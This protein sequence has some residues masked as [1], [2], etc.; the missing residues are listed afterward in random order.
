[1]VTRAPRWIILAALALVA[2]NLRSVLTSLPPLVTEIQADTGWSDVTIGLLTT[3]PVLLMGATAL[4]VPR[5]AEHVGRIQTVWL[6]LALLTIAVLARLA[7]AVPGVLHASVI[8]AGI[9]IA[10]AA[11][12]VPG[13]V[14][15]QVPRAIGPATGIWT[16]AMFTGATL[17]A[18]LAVPFAVAAGSWQV[19]LAVWAI[20]AAVAFVMWAIVETPYRRHVREGIASVRISALPWHS[21][22]AW[23]LTAYLALNSLVFYSAV[24][25]LAPSLDERGWSAAESGWLFAL[26]AASQIVAALIMPALTERLPGR[27]IVWIV[28]ALLTFASLMSIAYVPTFATAAVLFLFG[29]C[30]SGGFTIGLAMLSEFATDADAS[31]RLTAMAFAITY[32]VGATGP[33]VTGLLIEW[34]GSWTLVY[35]VLAVA[36]LA[37]ILTVLP[38]RRGTVIA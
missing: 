3:L 24:A 34:S 17:G 38:L 2:L 4:L 32:L 20:P 9:G 8:L 1:M 15:E 25:W 12:L 5:I 37:Q 7:G 30:N 27:R 35:V 18:A 6:A 26:F 23:A 22:P 33:T 16:A 10:L 28:T 31:A 13:I 36:S 11:G 21:G 19:G 29:L 14:R